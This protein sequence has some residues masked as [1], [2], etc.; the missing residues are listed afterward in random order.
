MCLPSRCL[1][2][3]VY[4]DFTISAFGRHVTIYFLYHL[5]YLQPGTIKSCGTHLKI[6]FMP[7]LIPWEHQFELEVIVNNAHALVL[8]YIYTAGASSMTIAVSSEPPMHRS[9]LIFLSPYNKAYGI[10]WAMKR[11]QI[12][13]TW[14]CTQICLLNDECHVKKALLS[15]RWLLEH[16]FKANSAYT[17][18]FM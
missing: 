6:N 14:P 18:I 17:P 16:A 12:S 1:A 2:M 4:S 10:W 15:H 3:N 11:I 13:E 8:R 5:L 9:I 7:A